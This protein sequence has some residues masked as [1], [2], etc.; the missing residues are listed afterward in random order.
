[1]RAADTLTSAVRG[2]VRRPL[3]GV[4]TAIAVGIGAF[5]FTVTSGL[6]TGINDYIDSQTRAVG[7][8]DTVQVTAQNMQSFLNERPE[9]FDDDMIEGGADLGTG[10]LSEEAV[11]AIEGVLAE[12]D[13]ILPGQQV[14]PLYVEYEGGPRYRFVYNGHW[15]GKTA[16]LA[17][18]AQLSDETSSPE[19]IIPTY[20]VP[21]LGFSSDKGAVGEQVDVGV[22]GA[23]GEVR[24]IQA[25][26]VGV[27]LR[28]LIGGN[29]PF[30]NAAFQQELEVASAAGSDPT[31]P[32]FYTSVLVTGPDI[33]RTAERIRGLGYSVQ[34]P[35]QIVGDYKTIVSAVLLILN[36]LAG[37]AIMAAMFGIVNTLLM[38]VQERTRQIGM[39]RALGMHRRDV[40]ASIALEALIIGI[41]GSVLA[42]VVAMALGTVLGPEILR[43][44]G[45]DLPGLRLF[46]FDPL[47]ILLILATVSVASLL[48]SLLP[49]LRAA[50]VDPMA[51][52]REEV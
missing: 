48:A 43:M 40:F 26:V 46:V 8:T 32:Q 42:I 21:A 50:S 25:T 9:R 37:I 41:V 5:T 45:L 15:P 38:T 39:Q 22:R 51:A 10:I 47:S 23:D 6:G 29:L 44:I 30:G 35:E 11:S 17:A 13:K 52:M 33:E 7:A 34:T 31:A 24:Q 19:I 27:Q 4:L 49:A 12:K 18:G 14:A 3:R 28:S 20:L 36:V 16:N 1:M 2:V